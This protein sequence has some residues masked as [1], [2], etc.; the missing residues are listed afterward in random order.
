M[1][2]E[3][4]QLS[5]FLSHGTRTPVIG[6]TT[7][8]LWLF[9]GPN[10]S[11]KT[12]VFEAIEF[13]LYGHHRLGAR[14]HVGR[15][16]RQGE[17]KAWIEVIFTHGGQR[18]RVTRQVSRDD[19]NEGG[20]IFREEDRRWEP[21]REAGTGKQA[22]WDYVQ[23]HIMP[24][25]HF[26]SGVYL[27]QDGLGY[28]L[29]EGPDQRGRR[30]ASLMDLEE[31][32]QLAEFAQ[33]HTQ[34]EGAKA[35][36]L[37]EAL[38]QY[39]DLSSEAHERALTAMVEAD[40]M[41][42]VA[43][44]AAEGAATL[45]QDARDWNEGQGQLGELDES[46]NAQ[47]VLLTEAETIRAAAV[48]VLS[49]HAIKP[50][51]DRF[52]NHL[53]E[54]AGYRNQSIE[55]QRLGWAA[56]QEAQ[57][58]Q[59]TSDELQIRL[60]NLRD[61]QIPALQLQAR[62]AEAEC[63]ASELEY[64]IAQQ[65][66]RVQKAQKTIDQLSGA[67]AALRTW[68]EARRAV[69]RLQELVEAKASVRSLERQLAQL[70][71][72]L[73]SFIEEKKMAAAT[74]LESKRKLT[75]CEQVYRRAEVAFEELGRQIETL[76]SEI[77]KHQELSGK[78]RRCPVCDQVLNQPARAHV[79]QA[80]QSKR[81]KL[82]TLRLDTRQS[83]LQR[84]KA[85]LAHA[86]AVGALSRAQTRLQ[87]LERRL[88]EANSKIQTLIARLKSEKSRVARALKA[89]QREART[90]ASQL[91]NMTMRQ[92]KAL[93]HQLGREEAVFRANASKYVQAQRTL[94]DAKS[95]ARALRARRLGE[96]PASFGDNDKP[97]KIA[98]IRAKAL[99]KLAEAQAAVEQADA[100]LTSLLEELNRILPLQ[101]AKAT[102]AEQNHLLAHQFQTQAEESER[103][104]AEINVPEP[105]IACLRSREAY[106]Q[107][108][109][110]IGQLR[111][112]AERLPA[113]DEAEATLA[114]LN[115]QRLMLLE[116]LEIIPEAHRIPLED[117]RKQRVDVGAK[118]QLMQTHRDEVLQAKAQLEANQA[119]AEQLQRNEQQADHRR[120]VFSDLARMLG[121]DGP[122]QHRVIQSVQEEICRL[123]NEILRRAGDS[124][125]IWLGEPL[126]AGSLEKDLVFVDR[127]EPSV[128]DRLYEQ[129]SAGEKTRVAMAIAAVIHG[130]ASGGEVGTLI[131]DEAFGALDE[132]HRQAYAAEVSDVTS[133]WLEQG[134]VG[135]II[136][137]THVADVHQFFPAYYRITKVDGQ[138][139][140]VCS[141][142]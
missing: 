79:R 27:H 84:T 41:V 34:D 53:D 31:L 51:L 99:A 40:T 121:P 59:K 93:D 18:Y 92:V 52:W 89:A 72:A 8:P 105:W 75:V 103:L 128:G 25:E 132:D 35:T 133:G 82:R 56:A 10:G 22:V 94:E 107:Q 43:Q 54:A 64:Q 142:P 4:V 32:N 57:S 139:H 115:R 118:L 17:D 69:P 2:I 85:S 26:C 135:Q 74:A 1:R 138:A 110:A 73:R 109:T 28:F 68:E 62:E 120:Q 102:M 114:G 80:I 88:I 87:R 20:S 78:A 70:R 136:V 6:L 50:Q 100:E 33:R 71:R 37:R 81:A 117:A 55:A 130:R 96:A 141:A 42:K 19:G 137:A 95:Q 39:G 111:P 116:R 129:L 23:K 119:Q 30:F 46:I 14:K 90:Y 47:Q 44:Q 97:E 38:S 127:Q 134:L 21:V 48:I 101:A 24:Y 113:L 140:V 15:L 123:A 3:S 83:K 61:T 5:N 29:S 67:S 12:S 112:L 16:V 36:A 124:L 108:S 63:Q 125:E 98:R 65:L 66:E 9:V 7:S 11:G 86:R 91:A 77:E 49:W 76:T 131:I 106:K 13:A 58:L 45:E 104:A 122:V 126:R 60:A